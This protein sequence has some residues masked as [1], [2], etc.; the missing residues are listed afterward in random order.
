M[1]RS[2]TSVTKMSMEEIAK[3]LKASPDL[4]THGFFNAFTEFIRVKGGMS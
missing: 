4:F 3:K 1:S 2:R